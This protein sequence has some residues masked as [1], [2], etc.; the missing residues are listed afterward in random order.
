MDIN[1]QINACGD[2]VPLNNEINNL[3]IVFPAMIVKLILLVNIEV[4]NEIYL[5]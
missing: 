3:S 2:A 4:F 1:K 5:H